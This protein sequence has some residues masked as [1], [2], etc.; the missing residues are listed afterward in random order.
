MGRTEIEMSFKSVGVRMIRHSKP[1]CKSTRLM[2]Y[3]RDTQSPV[4]CNNPSSDST[5]CTTFVLDAWNL[6][7]KSNL[8]DLAQGI[9]CSGCSLVPKTTWLKF[10]SSNEAALY[11]LRSIFLVGKKAW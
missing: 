7:A 8:Q 5:C 2:G 4:V 3:G 1:T 6:W 9:D 11:E 10:Q